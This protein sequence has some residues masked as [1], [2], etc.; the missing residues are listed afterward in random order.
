VRLHR[1]YKFLSAHEAFP[2][3]YLL[4]CVRRTLKNPIRCVIESPLFYEGWAYY[5]ESL[6]DEDGYVRT[7]IERLVH[8]KRTLWR[9]ARCMIDSGLPTGCIDRT[10]AEKLMEEVGYTQDEA[11]QL[12]NRF[13]LNPGYHLCYTLGKF[14]ILNLRNR[15]GTLLGRD[16]FHRILLEGGELPFHLIERRFK[17]CIGGKN[18]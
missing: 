13:Q 12:V 2:G 5:A 6:L 15:Y 4:D 18:N 11:A 1:E 10:E 7:P 16:A 9:A 17:A 14:E 8:N 3:H